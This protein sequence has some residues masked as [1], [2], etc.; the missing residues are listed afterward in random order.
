MPL[1]ELRL[2]ASY[3]PSLTAVEVV[4]AQSDALAQAGAAITAFWPPFTSDE[5]R[6]GLAEF[7]RH[8]AAH[9]PKNDGH[10]RLI[11]SHD[12]LVQGSREKDRWE[13]VYNQA[14]DEAASPAWL[15]LLLALGEALGRSDRLL[16]V[17]VYRGS[18]ATVEFP[19][20]PPLSPNH[21]P[22]RTIPR[23]TDPGAG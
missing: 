6:G 7:E 9:P 1:P 14:G 4:R 20:A 8:V 10:F 23:P 11:G 15:A 21:M 12:V 3:P 22:T 17:Q 5:R 19:L 13:V 18:L 2:F 16:R